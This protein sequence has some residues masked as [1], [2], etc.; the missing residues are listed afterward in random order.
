MRQLVSGGT[1]RLRDASIGPLSGI[2]ISRLLRENA[3]LKV[4]DLSGNSLRKE[5]MEAI[6]AGLQGSTSLLKLNISRNEIFPLGA[7]AVANLIVSTP[8]L[9]KL[10]IAENNITN[11]GAE[12]EGFSKIVQAVVSSKSITHVCFSKNVLRDSETVLAALRQLIVEGS[13]LEEI[14]LSQ[15]Q[16]TFEGGQA[17]ASAIVEVG[18]K[19]ALRSLCLAGN[20]LGSTGTLPIIEAI[21]TSGI[22]LEEINIQKNN[23][24]E[25][26]AFAILDLLAH[27]R[28]EWPKLE[29]IDVQGNRIPDALKR[30]SSPTSMEANRYGIVTVASRISFF[31]IV[32]RECEEEKNPKRRSHAGA[33]EDDVSSSKEEEERDE[34]AQDYQDEGKVEVSSSSSSSMH[35]QTD[36]VGFRATSPAT[37]SPPGSERLSSRSENSPKTDQK[38]DASSRFGSKSMSTAT[39]DSKFENDDVDSDDSMDDDEIK[40]MQ[41]AYASMGGRSYVD[42]DATENSAAAYAAHAQAASR[43]P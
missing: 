3:S 9:T 27:H 37:C 16:L 5:G 23:I 32:R 28:D 30:G 39:D 35:L 33:K 24:T 41:I 19:T 40:A 42:F 36:I 13:S 22:G 6:C 15:T 25:G 12:P 17:I 34:T 20:A 14:D 4:A 29:T 7:E 43:N 1:V 18:G 10:S 8:Q 31:K 26:T 38:K 21:C 11:W 2:V